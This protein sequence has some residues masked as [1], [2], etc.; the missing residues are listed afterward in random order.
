MDDSH[1]PFRCWFS[2]YPLLPSNQQ[3]NSTTP[4]G[5]P[6]IWGD[7]ELTPIKALVVK[8]T[9]W[10]ADGVLCLFSTPTI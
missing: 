5:A 10:H 8:R 6:S 7:S 1:V 3:F 2:V 4:W 9:C